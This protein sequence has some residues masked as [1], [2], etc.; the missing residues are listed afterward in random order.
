MASGCT[1]RQSQK[2]VNCSVSADHQEKKTWVQL[3]ESHRGTCP[4]TMMVIGTYD[5]LL[6]SGPAY[7]KKSTIHS[8]RLSPDQREGSAASEGSTTGCTSDKP[9]GF[10][11]APSLLN[12]SVLLL[13]GTFEGS[14]S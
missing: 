6:H 7:F 10:V 2:K 11:Q 4:Y 13:H 3:S 9:H 12:L 5:G 8:G 14:V 1:A